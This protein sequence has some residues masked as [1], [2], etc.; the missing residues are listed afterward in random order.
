MRTCCCASPPVTDLP[1]EY[2]GRPYMITRT[3]KN[4]RWL[5]AV[6]PG[7][8]GA[9][10]IST[11]RLYEP[12]GYA[13]PVEKGK[14]T[15]IEE[16]IS[17]ASMLI[18]EVV[19]AETQL[20]IPAKLSFVPLRGSNPPVL[21]DPGE[22]VSSSML[23]T[24][25]GRGSVEVPKGNYRVVVSQ[26]VEYNSSE[27]RVSMTEAK[28]ENIRVELKRAFKPE[29]W[30]S[31]DLAV[32]TNASAD[33][34]TTAETRVVSAVAEGLQWIVSADKDTLTDFAP[35]IRALGLSERIRSSVGFRTDG[36]KLPLMG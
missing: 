11:S 22:V 19:D 30:V 16:G 13:H 27:V 20:P 31:A 7:Q 9:R 14:I 23:Y 26:G 1:N 3:D 6:P 17:P 18:Y 33:V 10:V 32:R 25:N 15:A 8:Y 34:R 21:G 35:M 28:N 24:A 5:A 2:R 12:P 36:D 4:G 29:G